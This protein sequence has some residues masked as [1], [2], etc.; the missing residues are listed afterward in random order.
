MTGI[1]ADVRHEEPSESLEGIRALLRGDLR[2]I[3]ILASKVRQVLRA[4]RQLG[5]RTSLGPYTRV[6]GRV[7]VE[8]G[9]GVIS[10]GAHTLFRARH[11]P[12]TLIVHSG[13]AL[14]LGDYCFVNYGVTITAA[15]SVRIGRHSLIGPYCFII[16]TNQHDLLDRRMPVLPQ[17]VRLGEGV[18][19]GAHVIVLPGVT[20]GDGAAVGAGSVVTHDIPPRCLAAGNPARVIRPLDGPNEDHGGR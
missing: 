13:G 15:G 14:E 6:I 18:W 11:A 12:C 2:Q 4:R 10:I 16:D 7:Q 8:N 1:R 9:G 5:R 17:S 3:G 19:L 20:I